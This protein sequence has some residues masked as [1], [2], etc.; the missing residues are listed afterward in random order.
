MKGCEGMR[1]GLYRIE[2]ERRFTVEVTN[3]DTGEVSKLSGREVN[4]LRRYISR[5]M[6]MMEVEGKNGVPGLEDIVDLSK[7]AQKL[8]FGLAKGADK[9][10]RLDFTLGSAG[11]EILGTSSAPYVSRLWK[12]LEEAGFVGK[13]GDYRVINPLVIAPMYSADDPNIQWRI[14]EI[15]KRYMMDKDR[16]YDGIDDDFRYYFT[17]GK[18]GKK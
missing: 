9:Y 13:L 10:G 8:F 15:W 17:K 12:E 4:P 11:K 2:P 3:N 1:M 7:P 14:Q 5:S 16:G 6:R 18:R